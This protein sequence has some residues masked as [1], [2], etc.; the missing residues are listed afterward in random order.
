MGKKYLDTK[1]NT[2][3]A[4][5]LD[6]WVN[7]AEEQEAINDAARMFVDDTM[8]EQMAGWKPSSEQEAEYKKRK[9][10]ED[11][12]EKKKEIDETIT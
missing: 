9:K 7:A 6:V 11:E 4:S 5:V 8:G 10:R 1:Q 3:E 12:E 2:V